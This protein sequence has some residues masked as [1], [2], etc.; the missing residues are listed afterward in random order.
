MDSIRSPWLHED[1]DWHEYHWCEI[2]SGIST[3]PSWTDAK[4]LFAYVRLSMQCGNVFTWFIKFFGSAIKSC[5]KC[6]SVK[7]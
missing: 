5:I 3:E 2:K 4:Y 1:V 7:A 6:K